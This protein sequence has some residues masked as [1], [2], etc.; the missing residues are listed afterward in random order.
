MKPKNSAKIFLRSKHDLHRNEIIILL[1]ISNGF[2][3]DSLQ[4]P[5]V[6]IY[7]RFPLNIDIK[8]IYFS[9]SIGHHRSTLI[10]FCV[11]HQRINEEN[12]WL[13]NPMNKSNLLPIRQLY[14][15]RI[16]QILNE[17]TMVQRLELSDQDNEQSNANTM[18]YRF[19][20]ITH[21][22]NCSTIKLTIKRTHRFSSCALKYLQIWGILSNSIPLEFKTKLEQILFPPPPPLPP[23]PPSQSTSEI[24]SDF[25]DSLT[26]DLMLVPMLLP[27]GHL[28]DRSTLEKCIAEDTRWSRLPRDPFT[29]ESFTE[30]TQPVVA[31]QLK[32][33]IDQFLSEHQDDPKYRQYGRLLNA[34]HVIPDRNIF[35]SKRKCSDD[36]EDEDR[37]RSSTNKR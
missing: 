7:I 27:S 31:Q 1:L 21:L 37:H 4:R 20:S 30:L 26:C 22:I 29:L 36:D 24:P 5:P 18:K 25:L 3:A 15:S 9:P 10:E 6:D 2:L 12:S 34:K 17:D 11:N 35:S 23:P 28:I 33:R 8:S 19:S 14:F 32:I 16:I 13:I